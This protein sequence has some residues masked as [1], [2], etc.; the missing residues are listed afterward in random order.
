MSVVVTVTDEEGNP[1][2]TNATVSVPSEVDG[3]RPVYTAEVRSNDPKRA[4][5]LL[6]AVARVKSH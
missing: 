3:E 4:L 1:L 6:E 5:V 2:E